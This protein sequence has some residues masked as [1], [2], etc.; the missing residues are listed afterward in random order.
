MRWG[1]RFGGMLIAGFSGEG[2]YLAVM[3]PFALFTRP[4]LIPWSEILVKKR[5]TFFDGIALE[6]GNDLHI[7]ITLYGRIADD[8][9]TSPR[10]LNS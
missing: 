7:P 3:Q 1:F 2:F 6:L 8:L 10:L 4:L 9:R 5:E